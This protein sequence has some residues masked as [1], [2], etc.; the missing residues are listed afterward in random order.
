MTWNW[1]DGWNKL[2]R[3]DTLKFPFSPRSF[4]HSLHSFIRSFLLSFLPSIAFS[5]FRSLVFAFLPSFLP[6]VPSFYFFLMFHFFF[7]IRFYFL[8]PINFFLGAYAPGHT[9]IPRQAFLRPPAQ[10]QCTWTFHKSYCFRVVCVTMCARPHA[11]RHALVR[12]KPC[13]RTSHTAQTHVV[14]LTWPARTTSHVLK[15]SRTC[16]THLANDENSYLNSYGLGWTKTRSNKMDVSNFGQSN[17]C[18]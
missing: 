12:P 5:F 17:L 2:N 13:S 16:S 6:S 11:R 4:P 14:A 18:F 8:T 15:Y 9:R 10:S 3:L 1:L 7:S